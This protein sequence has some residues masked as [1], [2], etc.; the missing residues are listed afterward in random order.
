MVKKQSKSRTLLKHFKKFASQAKSQKSQNGFVDQPSPILE[1]ANPF[2]RYLAPLG[3]KYMEKRLKKIGFL[4]PLGL[5]TLVRKPDFQAVINSAASAASPTAWGAPDD[6][7][8][9]GSP[10]NR[11]GCASSRLDHGLKVKLSKPAFPKFRIFQTLPKS[12]PNPSRS[13]SQ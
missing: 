6:G 4:A 10:S 9:W 12:F 7:A 11:G 5:V 8:R 13:F 2:S 1:A 3:A